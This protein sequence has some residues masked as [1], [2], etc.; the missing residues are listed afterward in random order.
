MRNA[1]MVGE[2]VYLR[3]LE[4]SDAEP[5]AQIDA[6][7]TDTFMWRSWMPGSPLSYEHWLKEIYQHQPPTDVQ[8]AVC[9]KDGDRLLGMVGLEWVD[10]LNRTGN[11]AA[12]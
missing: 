2:R 6:S 11:M 8:L 1:I 9:L 12:P 4:V 3:P 5:L 10:W 7:E